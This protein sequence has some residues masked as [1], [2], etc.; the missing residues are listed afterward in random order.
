[1]ALTEYKRRPTTHVHAIRLAFETDGFDYEKWGAR[2][3]CKAGDWIVQSDDDTYTVDAEVFARTYE[4]VAGAEYRKS[5]TVWAEQQERAGTIKSLE[6]STA[7][8]AGDYVVFNDRARTDGYAIERA[9][10]ERLY[11]PVAGGR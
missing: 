11:E 6:G 7:Y 3:H 2:Q 1:M 9:K 4:Q 5:G 8:A 10:F